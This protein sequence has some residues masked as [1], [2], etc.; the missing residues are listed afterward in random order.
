LALQA[1]LHR[2]GASTARVGPRS[3]RVAQSRSTWV[4][5]SLD[6]PSGGCSDATVAGFLGVVA[7]SLCSAVL[8]LVG[9]GVSV[10]ARGVCGVHVA[11]AVRRAGAAGLASPPAEAAGEVKRSPSGPSAA[12]CEAVLLTSPDAGASDA[13]GP[14]VPRT[15]DCYRKAELV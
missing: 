12:S 3:V 13:V 2:L 14:R 9:D 6:V 8:A 5:R 10:S 15:G 1:G 7:A 11:D 4:V